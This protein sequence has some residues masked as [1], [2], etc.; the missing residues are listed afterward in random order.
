MIVTDEL[1]RE[2]TT[3][4]Y[5]EK[6]TNR[7]VVGVTELLHHVGYLSSDFMNSAAL[8]RGRNVHTALHYYAKGTLDEK[9]LSP[10]IRPYFDSAMEFMVATKAKVKLSEVFVYDETVRLAA[11]L[12]AVMEV[13]GGL[14]VIDY[15]SGPVS[16]WVRF[17]TASHV[18]GLAD[19]KT[20][21]RFGLQL[22]EDGSQAILTEFK[23]NR[24]LLK[25]RMF[26]SMFYTL[27]NDGVIDWPQ[28][29]DGL[30]KKRSEDYGLELFTA[31]GG[32]G[33]SDPG[34]LRD[35]QA[36]TGTDQII[37]PDKTAAIGS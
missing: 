26:A 11:Q 37:Y 23:D 4:S 31:N 22:M 20:Y 15:K 12:D 30:E 7:R 28:T 8:R 18:N 2:D 27:V 10:R 33:S 3:H 21:R 19:G 5:W 13:F 32:A 16:D 25:V 6:K 36:K 34:V 1:F 35:G 24:D 14:A 29:W 9:S 17:Q